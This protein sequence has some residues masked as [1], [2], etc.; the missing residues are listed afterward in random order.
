MQIK[1]KFG[2]FWTQTHNDFFKYNSQWNIY[3][4]LYF[5]SD[6]IFVMQSFYFDRYESK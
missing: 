4:G 1:F 2:S 6:L 3:D 5:H